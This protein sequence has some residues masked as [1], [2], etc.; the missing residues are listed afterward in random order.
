MLDG[1]A[2]TSTFDG[3]TSRWITP[4]AWACSSASESAS[5]DLEDVAVGQPPG[6]EQLIERLATNQLGD[7]VGP[8]VVDRRLV[9]RHDRRVGQARGGPCLAL[10][11]LADDPLPRQDLD[12]HIAL[13]PLVA[14]HQTVPNAPDPS[15]WITR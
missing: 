7:E 9:E 3:F 2:G 10:E 14:R 12:R 11:P 8:V 4:G 15:R 1:A 5:A 6:R 13:E